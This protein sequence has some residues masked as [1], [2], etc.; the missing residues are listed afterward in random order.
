[1]ANRPQPTRLSREQ[2][3]TFLPTPELIRA[4]EKFIEQLA[5]L[6]P[7]DLDAIQA[8]AT[9]AEETASRAITR[10]NAV[11]AMLADLQTIVGQARSQSSAISDLRREVAELQ[12]RVQG[13]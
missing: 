11:T 10:I 1:M 4:F 13:G 5:E 9:G 3:K 6:T 2:L 12:I 8:Q 7:D